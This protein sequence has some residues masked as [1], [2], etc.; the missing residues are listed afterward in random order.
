MSERTW[1]RVTT[2]GRSE[3]WTTHIDDGR[4]YLATK[5]APTRYPGGAWLLQGFDTNA[6]QFVTEHNSLENCK[7]AVEHREA[8][9]TD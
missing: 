5:L 8:P 9:G 7:L 1:H 2:P 6:L 4:F 3:I